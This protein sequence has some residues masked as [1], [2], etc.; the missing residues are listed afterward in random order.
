[1]THALIIEDELLL[2]FSIEEALRNLNYTTFDIVTS[3]RDAVEAASRKCPDLIIA[4]YE[5]DD[6]TGVEAV[7]AICAEDGIPVVFV[8]GSRTK[9]RQHFSNALIVDKPFNFP[10]LKS[11]ISAAIEEPFQYQG[12][13]R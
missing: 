4:D 5:L 11:A 10:R 8:T 6:G 12:T 2:A 1:M 9:V 3:S 13:G 7:K